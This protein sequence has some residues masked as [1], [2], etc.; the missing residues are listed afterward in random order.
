[1]SSELNDDA[2]RLIHDALGAELRAG[3]ARREKLKR[4]LLSRA[5]LVGA[6]AAVALGASEAAGSGA[7][8]LPGAAGA[9]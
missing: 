1:M 7:A 2:R 5:A 9:L 8:A 4:A 6:P 3:D